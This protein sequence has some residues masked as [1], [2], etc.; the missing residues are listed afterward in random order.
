MSV[1]DQIIP[2]T[3]VAVLALAILGVLLCR[4][5]HRLEKVR[6]GQAY[7]RAARETGGKTMVET[8]LHGRERPG[9][10]DVIGPHG[11]NMREHFIESWKQVQAQYAC[12]PGY[13]V[14]RADVLLGEVMEVMAARGYP[15][16]DLDPQAGNLSIGY[17]EVVQNYR[18][19]HEIAL[20]HARGEA[21]TEELRMA[22]VRYRALFED[23]VDEPELRREWSPR[24]ERAHREG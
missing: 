5:A 1:T 9:A 3:I 6:R 12:D 10:G 8:L 24:L 16:K 13:A 23:L 20:R 17:P 2:Y 21:G 14:A 18:A 22:M 19:A 7:D 4:R 15:P 11:P